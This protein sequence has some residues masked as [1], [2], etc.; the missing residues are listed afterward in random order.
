MA[1]AKVVDRIAAAALGV[2]VMLG[3]GAV[4]AQPVASSSAD[5]ERLVL[6]QKIYALMGDQTL[7]SMTGALKGMLATTL[8]GQGVDA[9]GDG[10]DELTPKVIRSTARIMAQDFSAAELRDM[11]AFYQS[12]TGQSV[13][14]RMPEITRQSV[15]VSL[16]LLPDF[17]RR[18]EAD[19]CGRITC[20]AQEQQAFAQLNT[21]L[22]QGR[23]SGPAH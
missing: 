9:L 4:T 6:A 16:S 19:Y 3:A 18:F 2:S 21:R 8:Q 11:L 14:R 5:P 20:S 12:P 17:M 15:Q 10:I 22:A 23:A 1:R 13:L 7:S